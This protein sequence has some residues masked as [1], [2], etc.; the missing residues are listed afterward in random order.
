VV[1]K[2]VCMLALAAALLCSGCSG[3][4]ELAT[5]TSG[6]S[7]TG[8]PTSQSVHNAQSAP[9]RTALHRFLALGNLVCRTVRVGA[10]DALS[11][12]AT[13]AEVR[14]HALAALPAAQRTAV[15]LQ[16][17]ATQTSEASAAHQVLLDY[18]ILISLYMHT[19]TPAPSG[20][21]GPS[22]AGSITTVERRTSVDAVAAGLGTCAP[23]HAGWVRAHVRL[24]R[25]RR[26][27]LRPARG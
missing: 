15:S 19:T 20:H 13:A 1:A 22:P 5:T 14:A 2:V 6:A 8:S 26:E 27:M 21:I 16:R 24:P 25:P 23:L 11:T 7:A 3:T 12:R 18:R 10:P 9:V 4:T 17:V